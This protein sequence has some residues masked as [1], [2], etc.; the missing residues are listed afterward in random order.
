MNFT[1]NKIFEQKKSLIFSL[2]ILNCLYFLIFS[3]NYED[4]ESI[5]STY[6]QG[7]YTNP[8]IKEWNSEIH[9]ILI[10]I[11]AFFNKYLPNI[12]LYGFILIFYSLFTNVFCGVQLFKLINKSNNLSK[13]NLLFFFI[14]YSILIIDNIINLSTT[15][16]AFLLIAGIIGHIELLRIE[17]KKLDKTTWIYISL[18][19][20]F[21]SILRSECVIIFSFI[22][23]IFLTLNRRYFILAFV[24]IIIGL[25]IFIAINIILTFYVSE[26]RYVLYH[27]ELDIIFRGKLTS[28]SQYFNI[29]LETEAI[30]HL[31]IDK[32]LFQLK[33][34]NLLFKEP[35]TS[36][37]H[38]LFNGLNLSTYKNTLVNSINDY[39]RSFVFIIFSVGIL[40][41]VAITEL[42]NNIRIHLLNLFTLIFP[43]ILCYYTST[44]SRFL[45]PYYSVI[46]IANVIIYVNNRNSRKFITYCSIILLF[47]IINGFYEIKNYNTINSNFENYTSAIQNLQKK[48]SN[49]NPV[50]ICNIDLNKFFPVKP[51]ELNKIKN[52]LFLNFFLS[53]SYDCYIDKWNSVCN[54]NPLSIEEKVD[55]IV[56]NENLFIVDDATFQFMQKYFQIKYH[57]KL[58]QFNVSK[59]DDELNV[60]NLKYH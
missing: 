14:L 29:N 18:L 17:N 10:S 22:Y 52:V 21:A 5:F 33:T 2:L 54:C 56:D 4:Y 47:V 48:E 12:Q 60:C 37:S 49:N 46:G 11:Y 45:V 39:K 41:Y 6:I 15:R 50:I 27:K 38:N 51:I 43:L 35:T 32:E 31:F 34:Y 20:L 23:M 16:I 53:N 19:V 25:L 9:F 13:N 58:V 57:K 44:P 28:Q 55:Y 1:N 40:F 42:K 59:F 8:F 30:K 7:I 3:A 36:N 26:A 24:P